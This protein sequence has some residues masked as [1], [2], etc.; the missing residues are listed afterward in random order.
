MSLEKHG[1]DATLLNSPQRHPSERRHKHHRSRS[2][3]NVSSPTRVSHSKR[4]DVRQE[5]KPLRDANSGTAST[6]KLDPKLSPLSPRRTE[7]P[8]EPPTKNDN[9]D[10]PPMRDSRRPPS[11]PVLAPEYRYCQRDQIIKPMRAHHCRTCG[12]V[13]VGTTFLSRILTVLQCVLMYDHHCPCKS[14]SQN[15]SMS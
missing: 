4:S 8:I 9:D 6:A 11:H 5:D 14:P 12:T 2:S 10:L 13:S 1:A 15:C 3:S 7:P